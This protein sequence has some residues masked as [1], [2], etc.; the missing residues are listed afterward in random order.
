M[1]FNLIRIEESD[2]TNYSGGTGT[3]PVEQI[4]TVLSPECRWGTATPRV[5]PTAENMVTI[6]SR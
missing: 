3:H 4:V 1:T 5:L 6:P 2:V